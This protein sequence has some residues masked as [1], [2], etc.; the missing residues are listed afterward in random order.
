MFYVRNL[1]FI[2]NIFRREFISIN[3]APILFSMHASFTSGIVLEGSLKNGSINAVRM[4]AM[5][6]STIRIISFM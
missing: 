1:N 5:T 4:L 6:L 2:P 3:F